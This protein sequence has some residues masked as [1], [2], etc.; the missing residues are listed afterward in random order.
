MDSVDSC[1][2]MVYL[3]EV[4]LD[5]EHYTHAGPAY[6][7]VKAPFINEDGSMSGLFSDLDVAAIRDTNLSLRRS[8]TALV[9]DAE[10]TLM[11]DALH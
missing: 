10:A 6:K 7:T 8:Q 3:S 9:G 1:V 2:R 5:G 4:A 11:V